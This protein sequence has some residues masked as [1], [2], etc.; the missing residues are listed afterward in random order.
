MMFRFLDADSGERVRADL[1]VADL[2][3]HTLFAG[4]TNDERFDANDHIVVVLPAD[5]DLKVSATF[6]G[7]E[8]ASTIRTDGSTTLV[9]ILVSPGS[10]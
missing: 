6:G 9:T 1:R 3:G 8:H 4:K 2:D 7:R 10:R 5:S